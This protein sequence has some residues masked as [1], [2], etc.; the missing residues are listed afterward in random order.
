MCEQKHAMRSALS[1]M[2]S[3]LYF[4]LVKRIDVGIMEKNN[5]NEL[6]LCLEII[7]DLRT[8]LDK[9]EDEYNASFD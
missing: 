6:L 1:K 5:K 9:E 3:V 2:P 7:F 8:I 4:E